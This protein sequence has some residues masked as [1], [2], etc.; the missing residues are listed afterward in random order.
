M[1]GRHGHQQPLVQQMIDLQPVAV[2]GLVGRRTDHR[3]IGV[4]RVQPIEQARRAALHKT[5]PDLRVRTAE[6]GH[7]PGYERRDRRGKG[8]HPHPPAA[9]PLHGGDL[10]ARGGQP[11]E[12][13]LGMRQQTPPGVGQGDAARPPFE[14][15][16]P[17]LLLEDADLPGQRRLRIAERPRRRRDRPVPGDGPEHLERLHL[18]AVMLGAHAADAEESLVAWQA[19]R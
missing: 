7:R 4:A 9:E 19:R 6:S 3:H 18:H 14:E 11:V 12:H 15:H 8:A 16:R 10:T 13:R 5:N 17:G 2:E 1:P